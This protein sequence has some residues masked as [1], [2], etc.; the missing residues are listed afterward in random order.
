MKNIRILLYAVSVLMLLGCSGGIGTDADAGMTKIFNVTCSTDVTSNSYYLPPNWNVIFP[1][2]LDET[3]CVFKGIVRDGQIDCAEET[4]VYR[5]Y[6]SSFSYDYANLKYAAISSLY[7]DKTST[8]EPYLSPDDDENYALLIWSYE[9]N[10]DGKISSHNNIQS[11]FFYPRDLI[12]IK[13][14]SFTRISSGY[15]YSWEIEFSGKRPDCLYFVQASNYTNSAVSS[16]KAYYKLPNYYNENRTKFSSY[17]DEIT[18]D[19]TNFY[20]YIPLTGTHSYIAK[21]SHSANSG[22]AA[23]F[24]KYGDYYVRVTPRM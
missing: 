20:E 5:S 7:T 11:D 4:T 19:H 16:Y 21:G 9:V 10:S 2:V 22:Y 1:P 12:A 24:A 14:K 6:T 13:C 18:L 17:Y 3:V 23:L 15:S 8:F